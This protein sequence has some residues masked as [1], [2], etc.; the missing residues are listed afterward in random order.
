[1]LR[2]GPLPKVWVRE[3]AF[4]AFDP[5]SERFGPITFVASLHRMDTRMALA[6]ASGMLNPGGTIAVVG[7]SAN[8]T[9]RD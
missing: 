2:V 9:V 1:M 7:L 3:Y 6:R 4:D 8:K 5:G